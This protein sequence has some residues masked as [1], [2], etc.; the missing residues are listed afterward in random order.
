MT[1]HIPMF[2]G[3]IVRK[4]GKTAEYVAR[5]NAQHA[6][7]YPGMPQNEDDQLLAVSIAMSG[8]DADDA[9]MGFEEMGW[10][11]GVDFVLTI[12]GDGLREPSPAW[13]EEFEFTPPMQSDVPF[14]RMPAGPHLAYRVRSDAT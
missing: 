14:P 5:C 2:Y 7:R 13:L 11:R 1:V 8:D 10:V 6:M 4:S 9:G 12:S 3:V